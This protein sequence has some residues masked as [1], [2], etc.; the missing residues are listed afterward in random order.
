MCNENCMKLDD[1]TK[2]NVCELQ[3]MVGS[4]VTPISKVIK[5]QEGAHWGTGS[6]IERNKKKYIITNE[7][8][9]AG[10]NSNSLAC[11]FWGTDN[12]VRI[13]CPFA[14]VGYPNDV[15]CAAILD[16]DWD[17][18]HCQSNS[19]PQTMFDTSFNAVENELFFLEGFAGERSGMW[20]DYLITPPT[21]LLT[22]QVELPESYIPQAHF[23]LRYDVDNFTCLTDKTFLPSPPGMSGS[24]VWNTKIIE[25]KNK[26]ITWTKE[27]P[28]VVGIIH[29][30]NG[31]EKIVVATKIEYMRIDDLC[32]VAEQEKVIV[33]NQLSAQKN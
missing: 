26:G 12:Y 9:A 6:Y 23:A 8:V 18:F 32:S 15:A 3:K 20:E 10:L 27:M 5:H 28:K 13:R 7:H 17:S 21:P 31:D 24:L 25:C 4:F 33:Q 29:R 11:H 16:E 30:Y 1:A 2:N 19:I 22:Y 14:A